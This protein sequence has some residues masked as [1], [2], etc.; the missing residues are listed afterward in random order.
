MANAAGDST[1][2]KSCLVITNDI[3]SKVENDNIDVI[4]G[5]HPIPNNGSIDGTKRILDIVK[6]CGPDDLLIVLI[7]GGGSALLCDPRVSLNDL[8]KTTDSP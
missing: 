8:Q 3:S 2:F 4:V 6:L 7:S 1:D 5:G